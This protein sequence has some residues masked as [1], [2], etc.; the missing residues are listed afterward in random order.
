MVS[1]EM[2]ASLDE[3][4]F[5]LAKISLSEYLTDGCHI[6]IS[7]WRSLTGGT[8]R[9]EVGEGRLFTVLWELWLH[10]NE[11][12]FKGRAALADN[13]VQHHME[14]FVLWWFR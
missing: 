9:R 8:N 11:V 3:S 12:T 14:G 10:N 6:S 13:I 4:T 7:F 1:R 2:L 5:R